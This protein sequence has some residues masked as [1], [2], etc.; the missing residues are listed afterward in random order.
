MTQYDWL[1]GNSKIDTTS[2]SQ[3]TVNVPAI[4]DGFAPTQVDFEAV[5][6]GVPAVNTAFVNVYPAIKAD[7][8]GVSPDYSLDIK[9]GANLTT[10]WAISRNL[11]QTW[12]TIPD[13]GTNITVDDSVTD[14]KATISDPATQT[15]VVQSVNDSKSKTKL[16][17]PSG[18][19]DLRGASTDVSITK[20]RS[21]TWT[22]E[23]A[24]G[25]GADPN[26]FVGTIIL[27][28]YAKNWNA[29]SWPVSI[30]GRD[31]AINN[32]PTS[33]LLIRVPYSNLAQ[34]TSTLWLDIYTVNDKV[35]LLLQDNDTVL[36]V[37]ILDEPNVAIYGNIAV[38][39]RIRVLEDGNFYFA[40]PS[41][42]LQKF[43]LADNNLVTISDPS[44]RT[45]DNPYL[46]N[47]FPYIYGVKGD[48]T[49]GYEIMYLDSTGVHN[50]PIDVKPDN[51]WDICGWLDPVNGLEIYTL[52]NIADGVELWK[53]NTKIHD[54]RRLDG[55]NTPLGAMIMMWGNTTKIDKEG[56][57]LI[58]TKGHVYKISPQNIELDY[59]L[60]DVRDPGSTYRMGQDPAIQ[61][62][63]LPW[64]TNP[65]IP[66]EWTG[67]VWDGNSGAD[68]AGPQMYA[69]Q[70]NVLAG[71]LLNVAFT[72]TDTWVDLVGNEQQNPC[73]II[74][75]NSRGEITD[76]Q[77]IQPY[78]T[79]PVP[80]DIYQD[81]NVPLVNFSF[82][83]KTNE[84]H[85]VRIVSFAPNTVGPDATYPTW[86]NGFN[87]KT[88]MGTTSANEVD[89]LQSQHGYLNPDAGTDPY[90][91]V[92]YKGLEDSVSIQLSC[93]NTN[94][95][96]YPVEGD[97]YL[98]PND[99]GVTED[100][101]LLYAKISLVTNWVDLISNVITDPTNNCVNY[102]YDGDP[103]RN[104]NA[105]A[106][107]WPGQYLTFL[108]DG[109][110]IDYIGGAFAIQLNAPAIVSGGA[111]AFDNTTPFGNLEISLYKDEVNM[112]S[113][114]QFKSLSQAV[115]SGF[116][117]V[118]YFYEPTV[119]GNV[120]QYS[121]GGSLAS[122]TYATPAF[123]VQNNNAMDASELLAVELSSAVSFIGDLLIESPTGVYSMNAGFYAPGTSFRILD[124]NG[125][126]LVP[127]DG[128]Y[129][130]TGGQP[131][132]NGQQ[133]Q[134]IASFEAVGT[135]VITPVEGIIIDPPDSTWYSQDIFGSLDIYP[136]YDPNTGRYFIT[137]S[138][139]GEHP[140]QIMTL[141][142]QTTFV[143]RAKYGGGGGTATF[144]IVALGVQYTIK[145]A[146]S[147]W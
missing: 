48:S 81:S 101:G 42:G 109:S 104:F 53:N 132:P 60:G 30:V 118:N 113:S 127:V 128:V 41:D 138:G 8:L 51:F 11:G 103:V 12:E 36:H 142:D 107:N 5:I 74:V 111:L 88:G 19:T 146:L 133:I 9:S 98:P 112:P 15:L 70:Y 108:N 28:K 56:R 58:S 124:E 131:A 126:P 45:I 34:L 93:N 75:Y 86:N 64:V 105:Y 52:A 49:A 10:N 50:F 134:N 120:Q 72:W 6:D 139:K 141:I 35:Y 114:D 102:N 69:L 123:T 29:D 2:V 65:P 136:Y 3:K 71:T 73:G 76:S 96:P 59:I 144:N 33:T 55:T 23:L 44:I 4:P 67:P 66:S 13:T 80:T 14:F 145:T 129:D 99:A 46:Q 78:L 61:V 26:S 85:F 37:L 31:G 84:S 40:H 38:P 91:D 24:L 125:N 106:G 95:S 97:N 116:L 135:V 100:N 122:L 22:A 1:Q 130:L 147:A 47:K 25:A 89:I 110:Y 79:Q 143:G 39:G 63:L 20:T 68:I 32:L 82:T 92:W 137:Q 87:F 17:M 27:K 57:L 115:V 119:S 121:V 43:T 77:I 62:P 54:F 94:W 18:T 90:Y 16:M 21:A 7:I 83:T 140:Q 117:N